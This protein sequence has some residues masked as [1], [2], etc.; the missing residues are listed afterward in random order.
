MDGNTKEMIKYAA[1]K[2]AYLSNLEADGLSPLTVQNYAGRLTLFQ[3]FM[4]NNGYAE[5]G[6]SYNAVMAWKVSLG[7]AGLKIRTIREYLIELRTFF[8]WASDPSMEKPYYTVNPVSPRLIPDTRKIEKRPYDDLL[9]PEQVVKLLRN[10]PPKTKRPEFWER[11]YAII[12]VLLLT[13]VRNAELLD[14]TPADLDFENGEIVVQHGKGD[15]FRAVDFHPL[16]QSAVRI[17]LSGASHPVGLSDSAPLFGTQADEKGHEDASGPW[18][19]ASRQWLTS[20]VKRH[21]ET[22]AGVPDIGTHDLRHIGS[23]LDLLNGATK[24]ALQRELGHSSVATTEI[25]AGRLAARKTMKDIK[26]VFDE[27]DI[28]AQRNERLLGSLQKLSTAV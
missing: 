15:K 9:T 26:G 20:L 18:H 5:D 22:V 12:T 3:D 24:E 25:Y 19:K 14:L 6:P 23:R 8:T 10:D 4:L 21:V 11:N 28:Q 13:K 7:N 27:A 16:A 1:A 2:S 17:Y